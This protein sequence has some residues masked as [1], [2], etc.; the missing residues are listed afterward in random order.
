MP[1]GSFI[2]IAAGPRRIDSGQHLRTRWFECGAHIKTGLGR[3]TNRI[4]M[5]NPDLHIEVT[6][7]LCIS[8]PELIREVPDVRAAASKLD[9]V[10]RETIGRA[11]G[12]RA[13]HIH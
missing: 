11:D 12:Q 3:A 4:R 1:N 6:T 9:G 10:G 2:T 13:A 7:L 8:E 5:R